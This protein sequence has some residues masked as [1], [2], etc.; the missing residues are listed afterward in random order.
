MPETVG[1]LE[2]LKE[3]Y[4][5]GNAKFNSLPN[6]IGSLKV[7]RELAARGCPKLKSLPKTVEDC[8]NLVELDVRSGGKKDVCKVPPELTNKLQNKDIQCKIRGIVVKKGKGGKKGK[9]K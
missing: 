9:K 8:D 1:E 2:K 3:L 6:S 7:L 4:V 5:N